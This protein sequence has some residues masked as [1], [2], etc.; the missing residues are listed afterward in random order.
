MRR[1]Q[2]VALLLA[3][4]VPM[5]GCIG[6]GEE[7]PETPFVIGEPVPELTAPN[8]HGE[9]FTLSGMEGTML[10]LLLNMGEWCPYCEQATENATALIE[11]MESIDDRYNVSFVEVLGSNE[12]SEAANQS[13]AMAWSTTFNTS[14]PVL[15]AE[16]SREYVSGVS[17][18]FPTYAVVDPAGVLRL[19]KDGV[20]TLSAEDVQDQ[21]EAY[22]SAL[23][24]ESSDS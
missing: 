8:Q 10:V 18:G 22:L 23:D 12:G 6:E 9:N 16:V 4:M 15:H 14:H 20:N 21:Y 13:Y 2:V 5:T 1:N 19:T 24:A 7:E 11:A 3:L 17:V